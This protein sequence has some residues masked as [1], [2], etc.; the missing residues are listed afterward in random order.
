MGGKSMV[1][2]LGE[3]L[4][5]FETAEGF[6]HEGR[7]N[8]CEVLVD[9]DGGLLFT[10]RDSL[11]E[12]HRTGVEASIEA[13]GRNTGDGLTVCYGPLDGGGSAIF[14][15]QR[16]VQVD[17]AKAW[18]IEH[19]LRNDASVGDDEDGVRRDGFKLGAE[20]SVGLDLFGLKDG[21]AVRQRCLLNRWSLK[22]LI[23]AY[24]AVRLGEYEG[25]L[26]AGGDDS[27]E[28]GDGELRGSAED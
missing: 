20:A 5:G 12:E 21:D 1:L 2:R 19:P 7:A 10:D 15:K 8:L 3:Y 23:A 11:G 16:A 13:H 9:I 25:D 27:F 24:R 17:V 4:T 6:E 18:Q 22:L 14:G 28:R 26:M